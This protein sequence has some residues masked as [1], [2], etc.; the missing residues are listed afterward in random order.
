MA[1]GLGGSGTG[2]GGV[3]YTGGLVDVFQI[4]ANGQSLGLSGKTLPHAK[5][6]FSVYQAHGGH[7]I[8]MGTGAES[9][10]YIIGDDKD[11]GQEIGKIITHNTLTT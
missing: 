11:I 8:E 9:Q 6:Q 2:Y 3:G 4:G 7:I 1:A 5:L 10:L